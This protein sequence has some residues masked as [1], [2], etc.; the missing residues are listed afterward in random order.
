MSYQLQLL[1]VSTIS[2][3]LVILNCTRALDKAEKF[4]KL[5]PDGEHICALLWCKHVW[6]LIVSQKFRGVHPPQHVQRCSPSTPRALGKAEN[7]F[8]LLPDGEHLCALL[9]CTRSHIL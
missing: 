9:W 2:K 6:K 7:F 3:I 8:K 5:L 4:F 1:L